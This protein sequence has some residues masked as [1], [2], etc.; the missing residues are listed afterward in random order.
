MAALWFLAGAGVEVLN[1]FLRKWSVERLQ[2]PPGA[3]LVLGGMVLRMFG[4]AAILMLAFRHSP[5]SGAAGLVGAGPESIPAAVRLLSDSDSAVR[6]WA[7]IALTAL[8]SR[9]RV[10]VGELKPLLKDSSPNVRFAAAGAL[11]KLGDCENA[12]EVLAEG[13][14]DEREETVLYA[15]RELQSI[16]GKASPVVTQMEEAKARCKGP[17]G[18]YK[19]NNHATFIDWALENAMENC[20]QS[21]DES[22]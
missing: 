19:N 10:A 14:E 4:T 5:L 15:A 2:S 20:P 22:E 11:C 9:A 17:D 7:V 3:A 21:S 13:L 6:Y 1:A 16:A 12:L 8:G 18:E